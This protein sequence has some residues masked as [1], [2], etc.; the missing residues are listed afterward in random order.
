MKPQKIV[1]HVV[2]LLNIKSYPKPNLLVRTTG[3]FDQ[4]MKIKAVTTHTVQKNYH[5]IK[6]IRGRVSEVQALPLYHS[7][8]YPKDNQE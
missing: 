8:F 1:V 4:V 6:E 5:M 7:N 2:N 3:Y